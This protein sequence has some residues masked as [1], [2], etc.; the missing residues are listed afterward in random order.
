MR[1]YAPLLAC[2]RVIAARV[3][4][5]PTT[6]HLHTRA[7]EAIAAANYARS[8]AAARVA[9]ATRRIR[10]DATAP[11]RACGVLRAASPAC[12]GGGGGAVAKT[13]RR[14]LVAL[15]A[16]SGSSQKASLA[17]MTQTLRQKVR[18]LDARMRTKREHNKAEQN[19][20]GH[21]TTTTRNGQAPLTNVHGER[22]RVVAVN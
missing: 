21:H 2:G 7:D 13:S 15:A 8:P 19:S 5:A 10:R 9:E 1:R 18:A 22:V 20:V 17:A 12:G 6:R 14:A 11:P 4:A 16:P 3:A